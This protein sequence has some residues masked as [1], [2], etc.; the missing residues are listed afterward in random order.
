MT[1]A[2][3][4]GGTCT[5]DARPL[6]SIAVQAYHPPAD[7]TEE[8][9]RMRIEIKG[10]NLAVTGELRERVEKRFAKIARQVSPLARLEVE[11][12]EERNPSIRESQVAEVTLHLKGV[13]LRAGDRSDSMVHSINLVSEELARQVKRHRDKRRRRRETAKSE[14]RPAAT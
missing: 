4:A 12:S 7:T 1:L 13:T 14:P 2:A 6:G 10:R 5:T 8:E 3:S 9:D 11:L